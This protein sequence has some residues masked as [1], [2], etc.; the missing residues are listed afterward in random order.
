MQIK[1]LIANVLILT[2]RTIFHFNVCIYSVLQIEFL[3]FPFL[4]E[5]LACSSKRRLPSDFTNVRSSHI[6]HTHTRNEK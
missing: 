5:T 3:V 4:F 6:Q 1:P 2:N